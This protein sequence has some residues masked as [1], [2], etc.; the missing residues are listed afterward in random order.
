[1]ASISKEPG[2]RRTTQFVA[3]DGRRRSICLGK[4]PQRLAEEIRGYVEALNA[5]VI[6]H[7]AID[8]RT[9]ELAG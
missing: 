9:A 7:V 2:G 1:M 5:A 3:S 6:A 8:R 4:V